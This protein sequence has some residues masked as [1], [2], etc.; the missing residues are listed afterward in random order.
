MTTASE[1]PQDALAELGDEHGSVPSDDDLAG[2]EKPYASFARAEWFVILARGA[3]AF[4]FGPYDGPTVGKIM[5][6]CQDEKIAC[7]VT[8]NCGPEFD[9]ELARDFC[10]KITDP[11][12]AAPEGGAA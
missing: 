10:Q 7:L 1:Q 5:S 11:E 8:G 9:W 3:L 4:R 6:Q 2:I 12:P